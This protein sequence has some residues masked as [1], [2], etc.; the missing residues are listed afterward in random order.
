MKW[1]ENKPISTADFSRLFD[2]NLKL[3][4]FTRKL[5]SNRGDCSACLRLFDIFKGKR[6]WSFLVG[7]PRHFLS[8]SYKHSTYISSTLYKTPLIYKSR[9]VLIHKTTE[10]YIEVVNRW[11]SKCTRKSDNLSFLG[12]INLFSDKCYPA[13]FSLRSFY[14]VCQ[15]LNVGNRVWAWSL[16]CVVTV[17][18]SL[19]GEKLHNLI[20]HNVPK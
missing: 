13:N 11:L 15:E 2:F 16:V 10:G 4:K 7:L 1:T 18:A 8:W 6:L 5:N 17:D 9:T 3:L 19:T 14:G 12:L 20:L